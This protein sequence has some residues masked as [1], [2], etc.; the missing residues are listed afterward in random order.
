[1]AFPTILKGGECED[2][3]QADDGD[4]FAFLLN[5]NPLKGDDDFILD[6]ELEDGA[7]NGNDSYCSVYL[8]ICLLSD[9]ESNIN[10]QPMAT[11]YSVSTAPLLF[12][13]P[14][15]FWSACPSLK[16]RFPVNLKS[17]LHI[18]CS[19]IQHPDDYST[20]VKSDHPLDSPDT[21]EVLR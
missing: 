18:H 8:E 15:S 19:N 4:P 7:K 16:R 6:F 20:N 1:M 3:D 10:N 2:Q 5:D 9:E 11:G 17:S 13:M 12:E 21:D 14:E